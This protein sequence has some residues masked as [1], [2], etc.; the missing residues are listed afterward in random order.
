MADLHVLDPEPASES[1]ISTIEAILERARLGEISSVAICV[2][3]RDGSTGAIWSEAPT[4]GLLLGAADRLS[5]LMNRDA[6]A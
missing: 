5:Y 3:N 2:V 1:V 6:L 4:I